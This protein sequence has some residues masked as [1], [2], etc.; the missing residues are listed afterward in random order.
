MLSK[1]KYA[2]SLKLIIVRYK[3]EI[4]VIIRLSVSC[5]LGYVNINNILLEFNSYIFDE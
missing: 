3:I 1:F 4:T 5:N 2:L